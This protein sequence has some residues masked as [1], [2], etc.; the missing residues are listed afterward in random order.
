MKATTII[1]SFLFA[2]ATTL[3]AVD[4]NKQVLDYTTGNPIPI[5]NGFVMRAFSKGE[6]YYVDRV[7][8]PYVGLRLE[9]RPSRVLRLEPRLNQTGSTDPI[10]TLDTGYGFRFNDLKSFWK[11][12]ISYKIQGLGLF[13]PFKEVLVIKET[14]ESRVYKLVHVSNSTGSNN[15]G[16]QVVMVDTVERY[17]LAVMRTPLPGVSSLLFTFERS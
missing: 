14:E 7:N 6:R 13:Q 16:L 3:G 10:I 17:Q 12:D 5:L 1:I 8:I 9:P 11:L 4:F 15:I 2:L